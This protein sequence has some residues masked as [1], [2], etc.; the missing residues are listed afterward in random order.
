VKPPS[1]AILGLL[2]VIVVFAFGTWRFYL[3]PRGE[4]LAQQRQLQSELGWYENELDLSYRPRERLQEF[5]QTTLGGSLDEIEHTFRSRLGELA[6]SAGLGEV[7]VSSGAPDNAMNPA[8]SGRG[9][10]RGPLGKMLSDSRDALLLHGSIRGEGPLDALLRMMA[11]VDAQPWVHR[12]GGFSIKPLDKERQRFELRLD[13]D[14]LVVED[15]VG[16]DAEP[17]PVITLASV[18]SDRWRPIAERNVFAPPAPEPPPAIAEAPPPPVPDPGPP[19]PPFGEWKVTGAARGIAGWEAMLT[20][21]K[22]GERKRLT[23][24]DS[25]LGATLR[26]VFTDRVVFE[27]DEQRFAVRLGDTLLEREPA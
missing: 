2:A 17:P 18:P 20:N 5:A 11:V 9:R 27:L 16:P 6:Q 13:V 3:S 10:V 14:T 25:V 22:T 23:P 8:G 15:L 4:L 19:P 7:V 26:E 24:G 1:R 21:R 12:V